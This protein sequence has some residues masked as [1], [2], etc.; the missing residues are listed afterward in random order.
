LKFSYFN[1]NLNSERPESIFWTGAQNVQKK[2]SWNF[3]STKWIKFNEQNEL[4]WTE[5]E[6]IFNSILF[7]TAA[8]IQLITVG[9]CKRLKDIE[10]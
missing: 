9:Y 1:L 10:I 4:N 2:Q 3:S 5:L 8:F 6:E 7:I